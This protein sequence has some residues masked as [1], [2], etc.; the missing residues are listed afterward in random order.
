MFK[1]SFHI[2]LLLFVLF[3]KQAN[4]QEKYTLSGYVKDAQTGE[5][6]PG[7]AVFNEQNRSEGI[8]TNI[9]GF[10]SLTLKSGNYTISF[11][12]LGYAKKSVDIIL[13][14]CL[15]YTIEMKDVSDTLYFYADGYADQFGGTNGKKFKYKQLQQMLLANCDKRLSEQQEIFLKIF[16]EWKGNLE[17]VDDVLLIGIRV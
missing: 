1:Y 14:G 9:Y 17:Q 10:Y 11:T 3:V 7:V 13:Q 5:Y 2:S 6:I 15:L 16:N 8:T 4:A 12:S